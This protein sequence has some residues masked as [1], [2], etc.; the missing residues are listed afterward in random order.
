VSEPITLDDYD[1]TILRDC[2]FTVRV[3]PWAR[4]TRNELAKMR[5]IKRLWAAG[6]ISGTVGEDGESLHVSIRDPGRLA[7]GWAAIETREAV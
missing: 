7:I 5:R 4:P 2:P 6:L 3:I 1:K